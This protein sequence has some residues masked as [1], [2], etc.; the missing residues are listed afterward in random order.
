MAFIAF[1]VLTLD[2][3]EVLTEPWSDRRKRLENLGAVLQ[4]PNVTIVPVTDDAARLW[5]TSVGW[6]ARA[7]C[8][9]TGGPSTARAK[10]SPDWL[11]VKHRHRVEGPR[12]RW[13]DW[14]WAVQ[15]TL[16]Y[17]HPHHPD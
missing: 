2:G 17:R 11:K 1:D 8:S 10:R 15:L 7:S 13:G 12:V 4:V 5:A 14:G 3:R 6:G 16:S 9:R